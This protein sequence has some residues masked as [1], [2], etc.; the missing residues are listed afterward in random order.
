MTIT[1][2]KT[3]NRVNPVGDMMGKITLSWV[4]EDSIS[5]KQ[6]A[7]QIKVATDQEM[8]FLVYYTGKDPD[9][10]SQSVEIPMEPEPATRYYWTVR[11]WG[12]AGDVCESSINWFETDGMD[13]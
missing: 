8:K 7:A 13:G 6:V 10:L 4:I 9:I 3:N 1:S 5:K 12:D 2:C 11:V